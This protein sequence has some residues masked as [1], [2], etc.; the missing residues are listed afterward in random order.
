MEPSPPRLQ[1]SSKGAL[2][3][4]ATIGLEVTGTLMLRKSVEDAR[5][6]LVAY[7]MYIVALWMFSYSLNDL[8]LSVAYTS[9]CTL[10]TIGV[11]A[12]S[13]LIFDEH[14]SFRRLVCIVCTIPFVIGMY[15][16]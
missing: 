13:N 2:F 15:I 3:L 16:F 6:T 12:G 7:P 9:W 8:S 4:A 1:F 10:G 14:I 11:T 5:F